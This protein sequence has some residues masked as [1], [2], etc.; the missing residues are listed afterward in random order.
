MENKKILVHYHNDN[1]KLEHIGG[2]QKSNAI[3]LYLSE[4]VELEVGKFYLLDMGVSIKLPE[5]YKAD[6]KPRSSTFKKYNLLQTNSVGL[7]DTN[8]SGVND[9]WL[10]PVYVMPLQDDFLNMF[11]DFIEN[12][13]KLNIKEEHDNIKDFVKD[14][15]KFRKI[16][17][18]KGERLCQFE[19]FKVMDDFNITEADLSKEENRN[20]FGSTD[21]K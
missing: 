20:G 18:N 21:K 10:M 6:L 4:D 5:G 16:K 12:V 9:K 15:V 13:N 7:I 3:D 8:Y 1:P 17:I 14:N 19:V 2:K 11:V